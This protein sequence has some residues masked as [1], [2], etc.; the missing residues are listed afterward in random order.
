[1]DVSCPEAFRDLARLLARLHQIAPK[2]AGVTTTAAP[3]SGRLGAQ[4]EEFWALWRKNSLNAS[5]VIESAYAW[6]RAQC[7]A[8]ESTETLV[9]GDCG[10]HNLLVQDGKLAGLLDWE[11]LHTGDPAEDLGIAR[12]YAETMMPWSEFMREYREAGAADVSDARIN[13]G[14]L[15]HY[16]KGTTLVA[17]SGRNFAE[18][19]TN[20]FIKGANAYTGLRKIEMK[21]VE[22]M[23][24][25]S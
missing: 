21:I 5:P 18:G 7:A 12:V 15:N 11:F 1:M 22:F 17:A 8:I 3:A 16:L 23:D 14:V 6:A 19:H 9:H 2:D 20:D 24:R 4:V 25:V 10:P 13:V